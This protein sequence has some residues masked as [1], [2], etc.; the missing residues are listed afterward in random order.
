MEKFDMMFNEMDE[1]R[2]QI[3]ERL[4]GSGTLHIWEL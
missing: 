1:D 2:K 3:D 4:F